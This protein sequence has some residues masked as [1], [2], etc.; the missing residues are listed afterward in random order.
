MITDKKKEP[1]KSESFY[2]DKAAQ[3]YR[4]VYGE[5][6]NFHNMKTSS[7]TYEGFMR[8]AKQLF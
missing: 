1:V 2:I 8:L 4:I 5:R 6:K 3:L 7:E